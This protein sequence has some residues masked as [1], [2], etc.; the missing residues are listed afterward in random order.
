MNLPGQKLLLSR[1]ALYA[2][3]W[4]TPRVQLARE[5]G[6]SDVAL[7][8]LCRR[9]NIPCPG[10]G[11]WAKL[12]AGSAPPRPLLPPGQGRIQRP[13]LLTVVNPAAAPASIAINAAA[14]V[15]DPFRL[16]ELLQSAEKWERGQRLVRYLA[17][18]ERRWRS[19]AG[20][21]LTQARL[22]WLDWARW[23][24]NALSP[25]TAHMADRCPSRAA[26]AT[27]EQLIPLSLSQS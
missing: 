4:A 3:V 1:E 2:R 15:I 13:A 5:F 16:E 9:R 10:P 18:C 11:Y 20:G 23:A 25:F 26:G 8:R 24:A 21:G 7:G 14:P 17:A 22:T 27:S 12:R 6:I 19:P